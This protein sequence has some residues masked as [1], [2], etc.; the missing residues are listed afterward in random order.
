MQL[1]QG[2]DRVYIPYKL[3]S[4]VIDWKAN[5]FYI[6]NHA[7]SLPDRTPGPPKICPEWNSTGQNKDQ[8]ADLLEGIKELKKRT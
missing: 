2:L 3:S 1:L 7:P 4:K 6:G 5:W 8:V